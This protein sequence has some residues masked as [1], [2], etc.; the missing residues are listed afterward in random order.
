MKRKGKICLGIFGKF[1]CNDI[2][3]RKMNLDIVLASLF[4]NTLYHLGAAFIKQR[5]A[6]LRSQPTGPQRHG[7]QFCG[8]NIA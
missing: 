2:V 5:C 8:H 3:N 7:D 4:Q 6:N 1:V